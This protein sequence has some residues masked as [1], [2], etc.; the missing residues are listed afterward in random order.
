MRDVRWLYSAVRRCSRVA[1]VAIALVAATGFTVAARGE[2]EKASAPGRALLAEDVMKLGIVVMANQTPITQADAKAVLPILERLQAE[3][4]GRGRERAGLDDEAAAD[5]D[6]QLRAALSPK[7]RAAVEAVRLLVPAA[8]PERGGR[9]ARRGGPGGPDG[10][11][12]GRGGPGDGGRGRGMGGPGGPD[13]DGGAGDMPG[14][15]M[16]RGGRGGRGPGGGMG[17]MGPAHL[18]PLVDFFK[19]AAG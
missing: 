7:L 19:G 14:R 15:G 12:G 8:P 4:G 2:A 11:G 5:L 17:P 9:Q 1:G 6:A 13:G 16:G 3:R 10:D 18:G